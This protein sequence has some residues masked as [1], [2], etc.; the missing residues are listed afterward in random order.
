[1]YIIIIDGPHARRDDWRILQGYVGIFR[2]FV[3]IMRTDIFGMNR[4]IL[5]G[6]FSHRSFDVY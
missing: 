5:K 1:M 2:L 3:K 4:K 6:R